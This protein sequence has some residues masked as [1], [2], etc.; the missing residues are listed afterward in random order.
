[1]LHRPNGVKFC[2]MTTASGPL[3]SN[4]ATDLRGRLRNVE[5]PLSRPLLPLFE[6]VVNSIHS[7]DVSPGDPAKR[8]IVVK[9]DREPQTSLTFDKPRRGAPPRESI[10]GFSVMDNGVGFDDENLKSF[11]TLDTQYKADLGCRG[12]GRLLWLKAFER[13]D[14]VSVFADSAGRRIRRS[15]T[16]SP[17]GVTDLVT[18]DAGNVRIETSV[19]MTG[20]SR[21]YR[22]AAKK[23]AQSIAS[24]LLEHCLWYFLRR[25]SAPHIRVEDG[26]ESLL[27][28]QLYEEYVLSSSDQSI[29]NIKDHVF[30]VSHV[31]FLGA[32]AV[33]ELS[34]CA[35]E[36]VIV[37]EKINGKVA[38]LHGRLSG[39]D[40]DAFA[41]ACFVTSSFLDEKVRPERFG[42]NVPE[43]V[44]DL[45]ESTDIGMS[46]IRT[47]V[48]AAAAQ[49]LGP[50]LEG[51]RTAGLERVRSFVM[52]TPRY[53]TIL[54]YVPEEELYVDPQMPEK[55]LELLLHRHYV[56]AE[57][58]MI[59]EGNKILDAAKNE[60]FAAYKERLN[61]Y[62]EKLADFKK[63]DLASYVAHRALVIDF[64]AQSL[65]KDDDDKYAR[66]SVVHEL[67]VPM[68]KTSD[69]YRFEDSNLW[70]L[71]E[72]LAF[73]EFLASDKDLSTF[74]ILETD[75]KARPDVAVLNVAG[76]PLLL[77]ESETGPLASITVIEIKRPMRNDLGDD[78]EDPIKQCLDYLDRIRRGHVKTYHGRPIPNADRIPGFCYIVCD[79]TDGVKASARRWN[80]K[81]TPDSLGYFGHHGGYEAYIEVLSFDRLISS[82]RQ[83]HRA[84][85]DK[86]GLPQRGPNFP[87]SS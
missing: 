33:N 26:D 8:R 15:F 17:N 70:L 87:A 71:D 39:P 73:H 44:G 65:R 50:Y 27:L 75:D 47:A 76:I 58:A 67:L 30:E 14:V 2:T 49:Y 59:D 48:L 68:R 45:F 9:I 78:D 72:R 80:L 19:K 51:S 28:S 6:A 10:V 24:A 85:F 20:F 79:I 82:A 57:A 34:W 81:E 21:E 77:G 55:D 66:E 31:K 61:A 18:E 22:E 37:K 52:H 83:R 23:G 74:E 1:M 53:R 5:L 40:G 64:L 43:T 12:V 29:I 13:I 11:L 3:E 4:I 84:F 35:N 42:F 41:Y 7:T 63:S 56:S 16:F 69:D 60:D 32:G 38:G 36:R 86:L 54:Q 46:E 62:L 25:G